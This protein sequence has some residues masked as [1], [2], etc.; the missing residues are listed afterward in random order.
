MTWLEISPIVDDDVSKKTAKGP[1]VLHNNVLLSII[2]IIIPLL[3]DHG[4]NKKRRLLLLSRS[5]NSP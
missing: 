2:I 3:D 4:M 5:V 1:R